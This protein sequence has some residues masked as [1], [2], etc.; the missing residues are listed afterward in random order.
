MKKIRFIFLSGMLAFCLFAGYS[1]QSQKSAAN[2]TPTGSS[3]P[4]KMTEV[5]LSKADRAAPVTSNLKST[6]RV[7]APD[8]SLKKVTDTSND[9]QTPAPDV[10]QSAGV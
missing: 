4:E 10:S 5:T 9:S 8:A 6:T 2:I 7:K 1:S 3:V